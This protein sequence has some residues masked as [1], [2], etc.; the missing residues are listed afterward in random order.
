[1]PTTSNNTIF[2]HIGLLTN[3]VR[4][5]T[6]NGVELG[7]TE[8]VVMEVALIICFGQ[9]LAKELS[10]QTANAEKVFIYKKVEWFFYDRFK[11]YHS[12]YHT[13]LFDYFYFQYFIFFSVFHL[14]FPN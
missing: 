1:M 13:Q 4:L 11:F 8:S 10:S 14:F 7:N 3:V 9:I 12:K 5:T 6:G 2:K